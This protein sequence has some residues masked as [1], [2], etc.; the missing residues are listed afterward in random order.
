MK[1]S[2][3][4]VLS[5]TIIGFAIISNAQIPSYV[6]LSGLAAW[7][8]F[9]G[10]AND[11][12]GGSN[13]GTV[14]GA[15]LTT[16][17]LGN[18]NTAYSFD[19]LSN[20]IS[21]VD[22]FLGGAQNTAFTFHT[23]LNLDS[24]NSTQVIWSKTLSWGEISFAITN[25]NEVSF[26]WAN[27]LTG[28]KYSTIYSQ[29]NV[30]QPN[31]WYDI[32]VTFENSVGKIYLN[33][34]PITTNLQWTA[35]GGS[36]LSTTQIETSCNFSQDANSSKIGTY[37]NGLFF[38][39]KIDEFG[40]WDRALSLQEVASLFIISSVG[41]DAIK[42]GPQFTVS[43]N[44]AF[45]QI[46]IIADQGFEGSSFYILNHMG[47][48]VSTGNINS[49]SESIEIGHLVPGIYLVRLGENN[50]QALKLVKN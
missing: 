46:N 50:N 40:V 37:Q 29:P 18:V 23:L 3:L 32:V 2:K 14:N 45:S 11:D 4:L 16:G 12:S 10:D 43:P 38:N 25:L 41:L 20:T 7:Y 8:S 15:T 31:E 27:S 33:G 17:K 9:D 13:H 22:P 30:I 42:A 44:P 39:G 28:N 48:T 24:I 34:L 19:G 47:Q 26:G 36:S 21:L 1:I 6:P 49:T 5:I 35:Q